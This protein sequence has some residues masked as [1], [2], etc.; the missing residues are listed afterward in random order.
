[1]YQTKSYWDA[2]PRSD[3]ATL[4]E[5]AFGFSG[6]LSQPVA[7]A[8]FGEDDLSVGGDGGQLAAQATDVHVHRAF[9]NVALVSSHVGQERLAGEHLSSM[10]GQEV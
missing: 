8:P 2:P 7:H 4:F 9:V 1:M 3:I 5:V 10:A 6:V